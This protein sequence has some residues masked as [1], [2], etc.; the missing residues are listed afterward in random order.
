MIEKS[1]CK[2]SSIKSSVTKVDKHIPYG[3]SVCTIW[4][5]NCIKAK[6]NVYWGKPCMKKFFKKP[7]DTIDGRVGTIWKTKIYDTFAEE[8]LKKRMLMIKKCKKVR[9][10]CYYTSTYKESANSICNLRCSVPNEIPV[11]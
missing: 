2:K 1:E 9:D 10:H 4:K 5:F 11:I 6:Q 7:N 8:N 3:Y